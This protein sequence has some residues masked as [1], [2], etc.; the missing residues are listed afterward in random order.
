MGATSLFL[1]AA[2]HML[3]SIPDAKRLVGAADAL[4]RAGQLVVAG[5][6][7]EGMYRAEAALP[8]LSRTADTAAVMRRHRL[9][10]LTLYQSAKAY[11]AAAALLLSTRLPRHAERAFDT[12]EGAGLWVEAVEALQ[13]ALSATGGGGS[14]GGGGGTAAGQARPAPA[15]LGGR[16]VSDIVARFFDARG[17]A[18]DSAA[19]R[20]RML[21]FLE[22]E[23]QLRVLREHGA[24]PEWL[25][26]L[27]ESRGEPRAAALTR[28][29]R[30]DVDA[31]TAAADALVAGSSGSSHGHIHCV[32]A[33]AA[34]ATATLLLATVRLRLCFAALARLMGRGPLFFPDAADWHSRKW[35]AATASRLG[36][37][38]E[39]RAERVSK[40]LA[41]LQGGRH[42][43]GAWH[44]RCA[45]LVDHVWELV[46]GE[47]AAAAAAAVTLGAAA[48]VLSVAPPRTLH[49]AEAI[50]IIAAGTAALLAGY[51]AAAVA[52]LQSAGG[53]AAAAA[54][55]IADATYLALKAAALHALLK[56]PAGGG[57]GAAHLTE[58][59][60]SPASALIEQLDGV[61]ALLAPS[62]A[63]AAASP[64]ASSPGASTTPIAAE[65]IQGALL[66]PLL[67]SCRLVIVATVDTTRQDSG[68]LTAEATTLLQLACA[69]APR[70]VAPPPPSLGG[71][72]HAQGQRLREA[73]LLLLGFAAQP[74]GNYSLGPLSHWGRALVTTR[75]L[76]SSLTSLAPAVTDA[77]AATGGSEASP[78]QQLAALLIGPPSSATFTALSV[79]GA[80]CGWL[81]DA[82]AQ[83]LA[84]LPSHSVVADPQ[85]SQLLIHCGKH[86]A[87]LSPAFLAAAAPLKVAVDAESARRRETEAATATA[88]A[89]SAPA[90]G[91]TATAGQRGGSAALVPSSLLARPTRRATQRRLTAVSR[92]PGFAAAAV[93]FAPLS[94][95]PTGTLD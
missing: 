68:A 37:T 47:G 61:L 43:A 9:S 64:A 46:E 7:Y 91:G 71:V 60:H 30:G 41:A 15:P 39:K 80:V 55:C 23:E 72:Y 18:R 28:L 52:D 58:T 24:E 57:R 54:S 86:L 26:R 36:G 5:A 70:R 62:A 51:V 92:F 32:G 1:S 75:N 74:N 22:P 73:A 63:A 49:S 16:T 77:A 4:R 76:Q 3:R 31:L 45:V 12:L 44:A 56:A 84:L 67:R 34:G 89:V 29:A 79:A 10:A 42:A 85:L 82:G 95:A 33:G 69:V 53:T 38:A 25:A 78:P 59:L 93:G 50:A 13:T 20:E 48:G 6:L 83:L 81:L 11:P 14:G 94:S 21:A 35:R 87:L 65:T 19:L 17:G 90:Q 40:E 27:Y 8:A 2:A 88:A 66:T